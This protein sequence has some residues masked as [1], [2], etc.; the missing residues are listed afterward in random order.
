MAG[1]SSSAPEATPPPLDGPHSWE[2]RYGT[3]AISEVVSGLFL[4]DRAAAERPPAAVKRVV[5]V[6]QKC[7]CHHAGAIQYLHIDIDDNDNAPIFKY[8][9]QASAFIDEGM[10]AGEGVLVHCQSGMSRSATIVIA[11]LM[12]R[13]GLSLADAYEAAR[14]VRPVV[15]PNRGFFRGLQRHEAA[16]GMAPS[17]TAEDAEVER[18]AHPYQGFLRI[19]ARNILRA[20]GG[21]YHKALAALGKEREAERPPATPRAEALDAMLGALSGPGAPEATDGESHTEQQLAASLEA[22]T[23]KVATLVQT[24]GSASESGVAELLVSARATAPEVRRE[25]ESER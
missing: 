25:F 12:S 1:T 14:R 4:G 2:L 22:L 3:D 17:M 15:L 6:T 23:A 24:M 19:R 8:T 20:K 7:P 13:R 10:K 16:L 5:N 9:E 11:F 18:L 21:D